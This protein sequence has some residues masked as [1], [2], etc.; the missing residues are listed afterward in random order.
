MS[1]GINFADRLSQALEKANQV[2]ASKGYTVSAPH[3]FMGSKKPVLLS[4]TYPDQ[5]VRNIGVIHLVR[6][7]GDHW[8]LTPAENLAKQTEEIVQAILARIQ[9]FFEAEKANLYIDENGTIFNFN[10]LDVRVHQDLS[11]SIKG[12]MV[13]LSGDKIP[14]SLL[15]SEGIIVFKEADHG[16]TELVDEFDKRVHKGVFIDIEGNLYRK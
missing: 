9:R 8:D 15:K 7:E 10:N 16:E 12:R 5:T 2:C 6:L 14:L 4:L 3:P 11:F 13:T 1:S